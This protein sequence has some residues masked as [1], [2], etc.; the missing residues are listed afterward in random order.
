MSDHLQVPVHDFDPSGEYGKENARMGEKFSSE[1]FADAA[2]R[3][4]ENRMGSGPFFLYVSFTAPHDPRMAPEDYVSLYPP[5]EIALPPNFL[6]GHPFDNGEM[7]VRDEML[8]PFPRTP[9]VIREH[10]AAYYAMITHLDAQ[11]GRILDALERSG[12]ADNT[13]IVFAGDNG[14]AVGQHGLLGKQSVYDHSVR[15]PL[16]ISG[17][18]IPEDRR[19]DSLCY[20]LDIFPTLCDMLELQRPEEIDGTSLLPAIKEPGQKVRSSV[21]LAYTR[22]QRGIRTDNDWKLI[23]YNVRGNRITQLFNLR[24]DP[25]ETQNL[26]RV[27]EHEARR[28]SLRKLLGKSMRENDDFCD[29]SEPNW[30]LPVEKA[31]VQ[32]VRHLAVGRTVE[33]LNGAQPRYSGDGF[34]VLTDGLRGTSRFRDRYWVGLEGEDLDIRIDLGLARP[35]RKISVGF[36]EDQNSWIFF[37]MEVEFFVSPDGLDFRSVG[38]LTNPCRKNEFAKV[39][40]DF[41]SEVPESPVRWVRVK[42]MGVRVCPDWHAGAGRKAWLFSDEVIVD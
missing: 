18:G 2:V 32:E 39:I 35:V 30:G 25:W 8:A 17:P 12:K 31:V 21:M 23:E 10:I 1:L 16:I 42:G 37:P 40:R 36:L 28:D 24:N 22:L 41:S 3:A 11:I 15:V 20:L 38:R 27:P 5:N 26:A 4:I 33:T 19:S 29:L 9:E 13:L 7:E 14:L 34:Q 6:P